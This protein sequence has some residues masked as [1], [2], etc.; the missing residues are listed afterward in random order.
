MV[1][2]IHFLA[3]LLVIAIGC[4]KPVQ[5]SELNYALRKELNSSSLLDKL[6]K[7][8]RQFKVCVESNNPQSEIEK[9]YLKSIQ[10]HFVY[11]L[12]QWT[13]IAD[14]YP[15]WSGTRPEEINTIF[16]EY[17][18]DISSSNKRTIEPE[19]KQLII[20]A[21]DQLI[22]SPDSE[23]INHYKKFTIQMK[24]FSFEFESSECAGSD[25]KILAYTSE[26]AFFRSKGDE[27]T[28]FKE[29]LGPYR[30]DAFNDK[31]YRYIA[32]AYSAKLA[33]D[34]LAQA[35]GKPDPETWYRASAKPSTEPQII[36]INIPNY[37]LN[38]P[39]PHNRADSNRYGNYTHNGNIVAF[40]I[41]QWAMTH[42]LGHLLYL[43]DVY[44]EKG[45]DSN[46]Q[47]H[48]RAI[49]GD[50]FAVKGQ[51]QKD[52]IYGLHQAISSVIAGEVT[53]GSKNPEFDNKIDIRS[54][55]NIYCLPKS[56]QSFIIDDSDLGKY[57]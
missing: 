24:K 56:S 36:E 54:I 42:E 20:N 26:A 14:Q 43:G 18:T 51:I 29:I 5:E 6:I 49:M 57:K 22:S 9:K 39:I 25:I 37:Y 40:E 23:M 45:F 16:R 44:V 8:Q 17:Y 7:G 13:K 33:L 3:L 32:K 38:K 27:I 41:G 50:T 10:E 55:Q 46:L 12:K 2:H 11:A 48:P 4:K 31:L 53:C 34:F 15:N 35:N 21:V 47:R 1:V 28:S 30:F 52:D 19:T